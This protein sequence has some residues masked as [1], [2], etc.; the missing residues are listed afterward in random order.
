MPELEKQIKALL[1]ERL[2]SPAL[3]TG[4]LKVDAPDA[5]TIVITRE[6]RDGRD[7]FGQAAPNE[8]IRIV[9]KR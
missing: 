7:V 2:G 1:H 4:S 8:R 6:I 5:D 3:R 9:I